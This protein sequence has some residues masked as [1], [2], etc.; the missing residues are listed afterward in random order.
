LG[1]PRSL[2]RLKDAGI[3][4]ESRQYAEAVVRR[5]HDRASLMDLPVQHLTANDVSRHDGDLGIGERLKKR[6]TCRFDYLR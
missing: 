4:K 1:I 3:G 2:S 5:K 6:L